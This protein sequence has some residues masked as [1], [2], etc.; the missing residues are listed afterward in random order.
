MNPR[1][2]QVS[3]GSNNVDEAEKFEV[4]KIVVH[5]DFNLDNRLLHDIAIVFLDLDKEMPEGVKPACVGTNETLSDPGSM[6]SCKVYGWGVNERDE[7]QDNLLNNRV[8]FV[9][10]DKCLNYWEEFNS[11]YQICAGVVQGRGRVRGTCQGDSGGPLICNS[12]SNEINTLVGVV[13]W[14]DK[15]CMRKPAVFTKVP[16]YAKWIREVMKDAHH[17]WPLMP[18]VPE[19][20]EANPVP[21]LPDVEDTAGKCEEPVQYEGNART[22]QAHF[23]PYRG[24][25][26]SSTVTLPLC[27]ESS[28]DLLTC[29]QACLNKKGCRGAYIHKKQKICQLLSVAACD[30]KSNRSLFEKTNNRE[31]EYFVSL[32]KATC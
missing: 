8:P 29:M 9:E 11:T 26:I 25:K 23:K 15:V 13:A 16:T 17:N 21:L 2:T 27:G 22:I 20:P 18:P 31:E 14:G 7:L 24:Y 3:L 19:A 12:F 6:L 5:P 4:S 30:L 10:D 32:R 1:K 28:A